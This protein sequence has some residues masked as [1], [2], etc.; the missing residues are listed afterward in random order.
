M[1]TVREVRSSDNEQNEGVAD[2]LKE[3]QQNRKEVVMLPSF[4]VWAVAHL[5][6]ESAV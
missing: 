5:A 4:A 1:R 2:P 6:R 3:A